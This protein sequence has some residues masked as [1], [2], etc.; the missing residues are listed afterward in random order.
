MIGRHQI[1]CI[2]FL[3]SEIQPQAGELKLKYGMCN[4]KESFFVTQNNW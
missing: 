4:R 2:K 1:C 3:A